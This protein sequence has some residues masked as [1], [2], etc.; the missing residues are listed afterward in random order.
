VPRQHRSSHA[1]YPSEQ[2]TTQRRCGVHFPG[3]DRLAWRVRPQP[4]DNGVTL[5]I[6][7]A[8][9]LLQSRVLVHP[10][11]FR[12]AVDR[13]ASFGLRSIRCFGPLEEPAGVVYATGGGGALELSSQPGPAPI[14]ITLW[15]Q[16][17]DMSAAVQDLR[18]RCY[19]GLVG[20]PALQPW[21]LLECDVELF[22]G[23]GVKLVEV[24]PTHPLH[25][26][27]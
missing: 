11:N 7:S 6:V 21:G 4:A 1:S 19:D 20:Q 25:W 24:P 2:S 22:D 15:I 26:R 13:C 23:V 17:P 14:G 27:G 8:M 10:E 12:V 3:R 9:E 5:D 16:V 18:T